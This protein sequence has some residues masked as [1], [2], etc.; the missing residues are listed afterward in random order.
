[1]LLGERIGW[2]RTGGDGAVTGA[3]AELAARLGSDVPM[4]LAAKPAVAQGRGESLSLPPSF[5]DLDAVLVNPMVASPTGRVYAAYDEAGAPGGADAPDWPQ[6]L[7]TARDVVAFL[8]G[9]RN[10]LE[11]AAISVAPAIAET[12]AMLR[13]RPET[14]FAR[15]SGSGATCF[16]ICAGEA[17]RIQLARVLRAERPD[18]WVQPCRLA[19]YR[20]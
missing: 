19:G 5:P 8:A 11:A 2:D 14:L 9:A 16:A 10:D 3:L 1:M 13:R 20:S 6:Q 15:M 7:R 18:W 17:E 12:L 4:C